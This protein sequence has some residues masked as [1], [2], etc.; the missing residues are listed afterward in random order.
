M[1]THDINATIANDSIDNAKLA[2][3]PALTFKARRSGTT[4]D[5]QDVDVDQASTMLDGASDPFLRSSQKSTG[6][7]VAADAGKVAEFNTE[8]QLRASVENSSTPAVWGSTSGNGYAGYFSGPNGTAEV[9]NAEASLSLATDNAS[10]LALIVNKL[11]TGV[12]ALF[13]RSDG[14]GMRVEND[15]GLEWTSATGAKT[16]R[17]NALPDVT[18]NATK[19]LAVA[20]DESDVEWV[21]KGIT[22]GDT[23]AT[24][25]TFPDGGLKI[26][27]EGGG[28]NTM[29]IRV[30]EVL[31]AD[32]TLNLQ[33]NDGDR[34]VN[35]TGD[36]E[37]SGTNTGDE[38][39][40]TLGSKIN[41][42]TEKTTPVDAD[43]VG[44]MDSAASNILKK[45]SWAN[46]K[47]TLKSYFD[48]LYVL[49]AN[50][51]VGVLASTQS[52]TSTS[53]VDC[54]G[55]SVAVAA[56]A[57]YQIE[58]FILFQSTSLTNGIGMSLNGPASP[59]S[60]AFNI[61]IARTV[62]SNAVSNAKAYDE[63]TPTTDVAVINT[64]YFAAINGTLVNGANAGNLQMRFASETGA[65]T[66]RIVAGSS[67]R[68]K[69]IA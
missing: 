28:A 53:L 30:D 48:T 12:I 56:N 50:E 4:G 37:L 62:S 49:S 64:T 26:V 39:T 3:M 15:G 58:G 22:D 19:V 41:S 6:G 63:F 69:K 11:T 60:I 23:L 59:T 2:N 52:T 16:T 21:D 68:L 7:N 5:P 66:A 42:A 31:S 34:I 61:T 45:L 25:L 20:S 9:I 55:L 54:T 14:L 57:T 33:L 65:A 43:M 27:E 29:A 40:T 17:L 51:V 44:L 36:A 10:K 46:I 47:A 35:I 32:R 38:T 13:R 1:P 67:L 24:G 8:G 18:G